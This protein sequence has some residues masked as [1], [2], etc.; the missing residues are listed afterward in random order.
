MKKISIIP[1]FVYYSMGC[2]VHIVE[3]RLAYDVTD[4]CTKLIKYIYLQKLAF[5]KKQLVVK[6][7]MLIVHSNNNME[8][9]PKVYNLLKVPLYIW[10]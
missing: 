2:I 1:L 7:A 10:A 6:I 3:S 8:L 4:F 9:H 5:R